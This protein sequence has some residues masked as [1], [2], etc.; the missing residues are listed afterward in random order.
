MYFKF[1]DSSSGYNQIKIALEDKKN[2]TFRT[3]MGIYC[4]KV[5]HFSLKNASLTYQWEITQIFDN[6]IHH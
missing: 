1:M 2:T 6:L 3:L 5:M 4:Y